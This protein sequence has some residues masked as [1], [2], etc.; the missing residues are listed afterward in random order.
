MMP[1]FYYLLHHFEL[2]EGYQMRVAHCHDGSGQ[3][4][5]RDIS[6]IGSVA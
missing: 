4:F 2:M 3:C 5:I 6:D 1:G